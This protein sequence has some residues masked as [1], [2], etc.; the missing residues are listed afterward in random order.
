MADLNNYSTEKAN[1]SGV[2]MV[3][4]DPVTGEELVNDSGDKMTIYLVGKDSREF[5]SFQAEIAAKYRGRKQPSFAQSEKHANDLL[6]RCTR[7]FENLQMKGENLDFSVKAARDLYS[8]VSWIKEQV[9]EF[10]AE[11]A[12][13]LGNFEKA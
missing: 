9:D 12:N 6:A 4:C 5:K 2:A 3:L 13:F 8:R 11:R 10:I 7:G 1:D